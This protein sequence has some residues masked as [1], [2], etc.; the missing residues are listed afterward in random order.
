MKLL[1]RGDWIETP[2]Y[3]V[4]DGRVADRRV[5]HGA[6]DH[7]EERVRAPAAAAGRKVAVFLFT[8]GPKSTVRKARTKREEPRFTGDFRVTLVLGTVIGTGRRVVALAPRVAAVR[9]ATGRPSRPGARRRG[10]L[11]S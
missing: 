1:W 5:G 2:G 6:A 8:D 9:P 3:E 7:A 11:L 10:R 4:P